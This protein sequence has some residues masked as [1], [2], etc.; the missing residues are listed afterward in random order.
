MLTIHNLCFWI[1]HVNRNWHVICSCI[2]KFF[3]LC[4]LLYILV[5]FTIFHLNQFILQIF[6][7]REIILMELILKFYDGLL[8]FSTV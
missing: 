7:L 2:P 5:T 6:D 3:A 4:L 1:S 8:G